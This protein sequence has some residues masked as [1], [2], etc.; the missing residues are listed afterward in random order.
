MYIFIF[1]REFL[2]MI[3]KFNETKKILLSKNFE[4]LK[5][6]ENFDYEIINKVIFFFNIVVLFYSKYKIRS[7]PC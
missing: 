3:K 7:S 6:N 2:D 5:E 1:K 4:T